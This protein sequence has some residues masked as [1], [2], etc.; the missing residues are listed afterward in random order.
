[1]GFARNPEMNGL[2][3]LVQQ[4]QQFHHASLDPMI[5]RDK[6]L[7]DKLQLMS[8]AEKDLAIERI[9]TPVTTR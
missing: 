3:L 5:S 1:M 9:K 8:R 7:V 4:C 6:F 2:Q